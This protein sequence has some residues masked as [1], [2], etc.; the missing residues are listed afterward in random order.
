MLVL[1]SGNV[2]NLVISSEDNIFV[3]ISVGI[4]LG[5]K[6]IMLFLVDTVSPVDKIYFE[7]PC[8]PVNWFYEIKH[9][10]AD[11]IG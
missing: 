5:D 7:I 2:E 6:K 8:I 4:D 11:C 10:R 3:I 1:V 9:F